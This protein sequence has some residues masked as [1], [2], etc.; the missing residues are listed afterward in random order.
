MKWRHRFIFLL[1]IFIFFFIEA[2]LYYWQIVKAQELTELGLTQYT[3]KSKLIPSRGQIK[4]SDGF[5]IATNK[6]SYLFYA[7]PRELKD[8]EEFA[9]SLSPLLKLEESTISARISPKS[10]WASI[11]TKVDEDTKTKIEKLK[12]KGT[13]FENQ[14][15]R[16]YPEASMAASLLGFVGKDAN[17][18]P[19]GYF[20]LEGYYN[21]QLKGKIGFSSQFYDAWGNPIVAKMNNL[22]GKKEGRDLH[23]YLNR[24][25]QYV[26]ELELKKGVE[27]YGAVSGMAGVIDPS[28]G[29]I[30]AMNSYPSYDPRN[31]QE[32]TS[33]QYRNPFITDLYEPGSTFKPLIMSS[34][35]DA[36][37]VLPDTICSICSAPVEIGGYT[38]RT[39]NDKYTANSTMIEVIQHSDNVGMVF[40]GQK[41]GLNRLLD[42][43]KKF[44]F[45]NLT[46]IDLQGEA[47]PQLRPKDNWYPIDLATATFGQ[48][49]NVT[50][51]GLLTAFASIANGGKKM[52]PHVVSSV[53][54]PNGEIIQIHPKV[55]SQPISARAAKI[56]TEILVNAVDNGEA[57]W[58]KPQGYR[59]AG[60]TGTAQIAISG[61][62]DPKKTIASFIGFAPA[63]NPKFV[64]LV[65][66]NRPSTS[67]YGSETAAPVFFNIAKKI[68]ILYNI[69][70]TEKITI[71]KL[72]KVEIKMPTLGSEENAS[73]SATIF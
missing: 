61:H 35:L 60:K 41:L 38:I 57:K 63:D 11:K 55:V 23:L 33:E 44:G 14:P 1:F 62:Y 68:L 6:V 29:G 2:R 26:L 34:A 42:Y 65:I 20:G 15:Q 70:P 32:Y 49:I 9:K 27:K 59:I 50:P 72:P 19:Q 73:K 48:G 69:A 4:T 16:F 5:S 8:K 53:E 28:T 18:D 64:M 46:G 56:M 51:I 58:A 13:G 52:E 30:L 39:W 12:I 24:D 54:T 66:L 43:L 10:F 3:G 36:G 71:P 31:Y 45:D 17:G 40:T 22:P 37:A 25:I 7:N 47:T 67:I 21:R